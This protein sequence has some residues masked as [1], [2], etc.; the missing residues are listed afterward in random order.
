MLQSDR[1]K[2]GLD[3]SEHTITASSSALYTVGRRAR[4]EKK[5][6]SGLEREKE[7]GKRGT[8]VVGKAEE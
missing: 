6:R 2:Y 7:G 3:E 5:Q 4:C 8:R 1:S